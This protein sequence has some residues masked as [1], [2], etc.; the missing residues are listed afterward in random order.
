MDTPSSAR[1]MALGGP[2]NRRLP[3]TP[4][5][6]PRTSTIRRPREEAVGTETSAESPVV[7]TAPAAPHSPPAP[8]AAPAPAPAAAPAE[9]EARA[10]RQTLDGD[11]LLAELEALG[12]GGLDA[13]LQ[14]KS[15][16]RV[17]AGDRVTGIVVRVTADT[18]FVD[19]GG[20]AEASLD[21]SELDAVPALGDSLTAQVLSTGA[22]GIRLAARMSGRAGV[23]MLEDAREAGIP[24][25]GRVEA[26]NSGGFTVRIG[27]VSAFCPVSQIDRVPEADL[28][29]YIGLTASF[30]IM[31]IRGRDVVVS[32]RKLQDEAAEETGAKLLATLKSGD[33]VEGVVASTRDFGVFVDL[34]GLLGL[35][36]RSE[37]GWDPEALPPARGDRVSVRVLEVDREKRKVSLSMKD[38]ALSPWSRVGRDFHEGEVY[39][40]KVTRLVAYGAFVSVAP[41]LEGLVH[42]SNLANARVETPSAVVQPGQDVKVRVLGVDWE[43]QRLDL[44]IKQAEGAEEHE[45]GAASSGPRPKA[46]PQS[47]G[48]MADLMS[49]VK[50]PPPRAPAPA[51]AAPAATGKKGRR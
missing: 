19:V 14:G 37:L 13:L 3:L 48:T 30:L 11:A 10:A 39:P 20:K 8:P 33:A 27:G 18:V 45:V 41:G 32:R 40:G 43:R 47:L 34:G 1:F 24:V 42:I 4:R 16:R 46:A 36:H 25:E 51:A 35:V 44:G 38:Q 31:D 22:D 21:L 15:A 49:K 12:R 23:D 9:R 17:R 6:G 5:P 7:E 2:G 26:R 50:L 28:D 29:R